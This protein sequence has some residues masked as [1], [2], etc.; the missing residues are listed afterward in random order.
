MKASQLVYIY[1]HMTSLCATYATY[2]H[3]R[4]TG[5]AYPLYIHTQ[6]MSIHAVYTTNVV[7]TTYVNVRSTGA[8]YPLY[9]YTT[10]DEHTCSV[11]SICTLHNIF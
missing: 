7:Y 4:S 11:H 10:N 1:T 9:I 3:M 8:S 5:A 6:M 2:I